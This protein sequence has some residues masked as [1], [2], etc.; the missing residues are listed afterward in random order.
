MSVE[1]WQPTHL[2]PERILTERLVLRGWKADDAPLLKDAIDS[3][4]EHLQ[5]WMQWAMAEP[6]SNAVLCER[7]AGFADDFEA[8]R[9]FCYGIFAPDERSVLGGTGLHPR[10]GPGG[11][12]IG[13]WIRVGHTNRGYAT[14]T[15]LALT[16][17][18]LDVPDV[19]RMEIHCD[20]RNVYSA[21][22]PKRLGYSHVLTRVKDSLTPTG[23]PRDTMVWRLRRGE[24][25]AVV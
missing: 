18:G 1:V 6:S 24:F 15:A 25:A 4:L 13:Y 10:V 2:P 22:V 3:S 21:A 16:R 8:G 23:E 14:E 20:P 19:E 12:E 17:I 11:L 7:L 5:R 9:D